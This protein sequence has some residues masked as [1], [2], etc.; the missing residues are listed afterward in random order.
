MPGALDMNFDPPLPGSQN[1]TEQSCQPESLTEFIGQSTLIRQLVPEV[2]AAIAE[3]RSVQSCCLYGPAGTGKSTLARA[4]AL[5]RGVDLIILQ[6]SKLQK[7]DLDRVFRLRPGNNPDPTAEVSMA[8]YKPIFWR[9]AHEPES[10]KRRTWEPD[11][12]PKRPS[13]I[14]IEEVEAMAQ[15]SRLAQNLQDVLS[16]DE[17]G[18]RYYQSSDGSRSVD[19]FCPDV[20]VVL[21]TNYME[22]LLR[23]AQ[24]LVSRCAIRYR[25]NL[26]TLDEL[27]TILM[28]F[29][30]KNDLILEPDAAKRVA[31]FARGTPRQALH[32]LRAARNILAADLGRDAAQYPITANH[33]EQSFAFAGLDGRGLNEIEQTYLVIL[34][35]ANDDRKLS[36]PSLATHMGEGPRT[37]SEVIEPDL[38]RMGLVT[39]C[40]GQGRQLTR[41]GVLHAE[42]IISAGEL[43]HPFVQVAA[44]QQNLRVQQRFPGHHA[45]NIIK[46]E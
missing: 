25:F 32:L 22:K 21:T 10:V 43:D 37:V 12:T 6:G 23:I 4:I 8:G 33:V 31:E 3:G 13:V 28:Q 34:L 26:Y 15:G 36:L 29:A 7:A 41:E 11:G 17:H 18:K 16:P 40:Q 44:Q 46:G 30:R 39:V 14:L 38:M 19:I 5:A 20:S 45:I 9:Y 42:R 1:L 27:V 24:P 2:K 35:Q